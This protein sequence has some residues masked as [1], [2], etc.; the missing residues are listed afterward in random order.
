[1]GMTMSFPVNSKLPNY[2]FNKFDQ[3]REIYNEMQ[4][5]F[6]VQAIPDNRN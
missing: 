6:D 3:K 1:M 4:W 2:Q 5:M